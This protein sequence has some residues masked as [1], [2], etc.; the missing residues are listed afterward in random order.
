MFVECFRKST[1]AAE[2]GEGHKLI[3]LVLRTLRLEY[4]ERVRLAW[5]I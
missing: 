5:A 2:E 3:M 1:Y 4:C